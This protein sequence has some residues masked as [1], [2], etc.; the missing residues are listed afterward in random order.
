MRQ[1]PIKIRIVDVSSHWQTWTIVFKPMK[2]G[3]YG[4]CHHDDK[5][6]DIN[7]RLR[8]PL[9][10]ALTIIHEIGHAVAGKNMGE[11]IIRLIDDN[12]K[13]ALKKVFGI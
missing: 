10:I 6:I 12:S 5:I 13:V 2:K 11:E 4:E 1:S 9:T 7:S 8:N 3:W